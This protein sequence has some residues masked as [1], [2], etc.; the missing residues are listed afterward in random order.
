MIINGKVGWLQWK[1]L[2]QDK[3]CSAI[4]FQEWRLEAFKDVHEISYG[5]YWDCLIEPIKA[6]Y[7]TGG[8]FLS[9]GFYKKV[10]RKIINNAL[11]R[12]AKIKLFIHD[13]LY[14]AEAVCNGCKLHD[15][16]PHFDFVGTTP[17][18]ASGLPKKGT[19]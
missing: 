9:C 10:Q 3:W 16:P 1:H 19:A 12:P 4:P 15:R 13:V 18:E 7:T 11:M 2:T 8:W 14:I 17:L 5:G 6:H